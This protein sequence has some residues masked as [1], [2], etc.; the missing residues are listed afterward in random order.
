MTTLTT[1]Q[2]KELKFQL[3]QAR[4]ELTE[5][6]TSNGI[7]KATAKNQALIELA[8][9]ATC[10]TYNCDQYPNCQNCPKHNSEA[11]TKN[12]TKIKNIIR[13]GA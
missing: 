9:F 7:S 6:F 1:E 11:V 10:Q 5:L 4:D 13:Y 12:L 8:T 2:K 3:K